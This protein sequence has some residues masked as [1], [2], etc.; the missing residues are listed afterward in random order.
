MTVKVRER[1]D[2]PEHVES[3]HRTVRWALAVEQSLGES[4]KGL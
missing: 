4:K 2:A 3:G 1:T